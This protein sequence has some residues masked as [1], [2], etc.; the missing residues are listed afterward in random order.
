LFDV[1]N[2]TRSWKKQTKSLRGVE[3]K[4]QLGEVGAVDWAQDTVA[5]C[6]DD[7]TVRIWRPDVEVHNKCIAEPEES[8]WEWAWAT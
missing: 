5:T 6:A 7:G 1:A 2:A 8:H 3:L 4:G